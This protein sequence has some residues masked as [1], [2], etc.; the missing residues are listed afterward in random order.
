MN[1]QRS[2]SKK[3]IAGTVASGASAIGV[4]FGMAPSADAATSADSMTGPTAP[5]SMGTGPS[6]S[7]A[8]GQR[9][10]ET[11]LMG[12]DAAT[13]TAAAMKAVPGGTVVKV[14]TDADGAVYE[15][16]M[17][18]TDGTRVTVKFDENF[19]VLAVQDGMGAGPSAGMPAAAGANGA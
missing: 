13:A 8:G 17:T 19:A 10:D 6:R 5:S 4:A 7:A 3:W 9:P 12:V 1:Q 15:A 2:I 14:E 16:H 18:K 11:V